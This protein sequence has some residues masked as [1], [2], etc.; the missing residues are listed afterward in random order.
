MATSQDY[1]E[2]VTAQIADCGVVR[3]KKMFGEYM[4]YVNPARIRF[5]SPQAN[6]M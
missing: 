1:V 4:V 6:L 2:Y 3:Y 5:C